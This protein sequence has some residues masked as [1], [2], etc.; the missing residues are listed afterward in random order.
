M[1]GVR[2]LSVILLLCLPANAIF[3]QATSSSGDAVAIA[4]SMTGTGG[5]IG[6]FG[7]RGGDR[8][9]LCSL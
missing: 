2:Y 4:G 5:T 9:G 6:N 1:I 3:A 8:M 7:V